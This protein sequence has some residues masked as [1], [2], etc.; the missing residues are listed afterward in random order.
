MLSISMKKVLV[1]CLAIFLLAAALSQG[2]DITGWFVKVSSAIVSIARTV[3]KEVLS[4]IVK[5]L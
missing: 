4:L 2:I 3:I 5:V 1:F